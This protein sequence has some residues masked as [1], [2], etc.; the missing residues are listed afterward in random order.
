MYTEK[1]TEDQLNTTLTPCE[2]I[3]GGTQMDP[4]HAIRI[5][6]F[7]IL[8]SAYKQSE[9]LNH[10]GMIFPGGYNI[11]HYNPDHGPTYDNA[12]PPIPNS[13]L[14]ITERWLSPYYGLEIPAPKTS[15]ELEEIDVALEEEEVRRLAAERLMRLQPKTVQQFE[16]EKEVQMAAEEL[17]RLMLLREAQALENARQQLADS[18]SNADK[19]EEIDDADAS[20]SLDLPEEMDEE[21]QKAH[22]IIKEQ[23]IAVARSLSE[24]INGKAR[25]PKALIRYTIESIRDMVSD[26]QRTEKDQATRRKGGGRRRQKGSR[27]VEASEV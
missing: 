25:S 1:F 21:V 7:G 17:T 16:E 4:K 27:R 24:A 5:A 8:G 3:I 19:T 2:E 20:V 26:V 18:K 23:Q 15:Y 11:P 9:Q 12:E 10:G 14:P 13:L 22:A 6:R